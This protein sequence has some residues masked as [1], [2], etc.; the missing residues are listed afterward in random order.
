MLTCAYCPHYDNCNFKHYI[1]NPERI[2]KVKT[3]V[4][5]ETEF[6]LKT[7]QLQAVRETV[8]VDCPRFLNSKF[9]NLFGDWQLMSRID[10]GS[11][12]YY[13]IKPHR[14]PWGKES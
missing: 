14:R 10:W 9:D 3:S 5:Y 6:Q 2:T 11:L 12:D 7:R 1:D 13:N 4:S 8:P